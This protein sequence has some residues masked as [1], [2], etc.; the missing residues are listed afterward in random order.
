M[1]QACVKFYDL[2]IYYQ[3]LFYQLECESFTE[4]E[5]YG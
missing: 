2:I 5:F 3:Y 4:Q 1:Q